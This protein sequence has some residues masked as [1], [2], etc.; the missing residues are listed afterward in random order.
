MLLLLILFFVFGIS[1][2]SFLNVVAYRSIHG[3]SVFIGNSV[4]PKCR[5]KLFPVD[6]VPVVSYLLLG[7]S[8]RYCKKK[9]SPQY[10]LVEVATGILFA[11]AF[12]VWSSSAGYQLSSLPAG[13]AGFLYKDLFGLIYLLF[14]VSVLIV[15]FATDIVDGLLPNSI[16][17]PAIAAVAVFKLGFLLF[18]DSVSVSSL[19]MDLTASFLVASTFLAIVYFSGE[20]ALGGGDVKLVFLIGLALGWL[21]FLLALFLGFLTG[22]FVA[23]MLIITGKKRFGQTVALGP[24]L[25]FGALL[26]LFWGHEIL[27][28]Y[29]KAIL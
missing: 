9:I 19:A 16:V 13:E 22:G 11:L 10:P 14:V 23:V 18:S 12:Y 8:C 1:V 26:A 27:D 24:F 3:G 4:C 28:L 20:K 15:L 21:N 25:T 5:H 2:G 7:G 6:L 29:L 17:L